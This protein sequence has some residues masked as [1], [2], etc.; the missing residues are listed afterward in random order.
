M[1]NRLVSKAVQTY[2]TF[3]VKMNPRF[4]VEFNSASLAYIAARTNGLGDEE[5]REMRAANRVALRAQVEAM[6]DAAERLHLG[7]DLGECVEVLTV[8]ILDVIKNHTLALNEIADVSTDDGFV[9][10]DLPDFNFDTCAQ[11]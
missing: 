6:H 3:T 2:L 10:P 11:A 9:M 8:E 4:M 7:Q 1:F 5:E